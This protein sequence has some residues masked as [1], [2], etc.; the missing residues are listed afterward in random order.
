MLFW[1]VGLA[2]ME[3]CDLFS[4]YHFAWSDFLPSL[5]HFLLFGFWLFTLAFWF[6]RF[7]RLPSFFYQQ[8]GGLR[9]SLAVFLLL[10]L[11]LLL[12]VLVTQLFYVLASH[13]S[14][15]LVLMR[16]IDLDA[17]VL[18]RFFSIAFLLL[19]F[20]L[21][22]ERMVLLFLTLLSQ[23]WLFGAW[24]LLALA[25]SEEHTSELQSRPHL[26]C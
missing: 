4:P 10:S 13:S 12:L 14:G 16:V 17:V 5:G 3:R 18:V 15:P 26:V 1:K 9:K 24:L 11:T 21:V 8:A 7:Y 23:K 19:T 6:F 22:A 25:R 2:C 20:L